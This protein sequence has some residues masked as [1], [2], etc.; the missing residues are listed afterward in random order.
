FKNTSQVQ[1]YYIISFAKWIW[2]ICTAH[3]LFKSNWKFIK[4]NEY[5]AK[6]FGIIGS[7]YR[8]LFVD[9]Y[10]IENKILEKISF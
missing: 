6:Y 9:I 3:N 5:M 1:Y 10:Y 4:F 7:S 8:I 2:G